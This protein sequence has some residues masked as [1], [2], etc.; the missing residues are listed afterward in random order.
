M[1]K[2]H[3]SSEPRRKRTAPPGS[4]SDA[5]LVELN[6]EK[7]V[8]GGDGLAR[9]DDSPVVLVAGSA[10]GDRVSCRT[11]KEGRRLLRGEIVELL[12]PGPG[13][14]SVPCVHAAA[15]GGCQW[16]HLTE[17]TQLTAVDDLLAE[18]LRRLGGL[19]PT[20]IERPSC[21][22]VSDG[23][24]YR[25]RARFQLDLRTPAL[26]FAGHRSHRVVDLERCLVLEPEL[27]TLRGAV[28]DRLPELSTLLEPLGR[29]ELRVDLPRSDAAAVML[30]L[31]TVAG[32][33]PNENRRA[34]A[35]DLLRELPP[36]ATASLSDRNRPVMQHG[37]AIEFRRGPTHDREAHVGFHAP[38]IFLQPSR[39]GAA[40]LV[41]EVLEQLDVIAAG[42]SLDVLE[43]HCG[44]GGFTLPLAAAGHRVTA[45][46]SQVPAT[47]LLERA[48]TEASLPVEVL[49]DSDLSQLRRLIEDGRRFDLVVLDPPRGGAAKACE[50]L[51][52]L[53]PEA[54]IH[55]SCD[56]ATLARDAKALSAAGLVPRRAQPFLLFPQTAHFE[57]V[58]TYEAQAS[59]I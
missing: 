13:R 56:A 6:I 40:A 45:V 32:D 29:A 12:S 4:R 47:Q 54:V 23:T 55:V 7:L 57:T 43:L 8:Q 21:R 14:R 50:L 22:Q 10:P 48:A 51:P 3:P 9:P 59:C 36:V 17:E 25:Q 53:R 34:A 26:G 31:G 2:R 46:E 16:L 44:T 38:G 19:D 39:A 58:T 33:E 5:A 28:R 27:D 35:L 1:G 11:W 30:D 24:G 18:A 20:D 52:A 49:A 41:A 15:C 42:R 37:Q